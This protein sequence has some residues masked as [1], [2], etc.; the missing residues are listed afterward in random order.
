MIGD[1]KAPD[2][3]HAL[4]ARSSAPSSWSVAFALGIVYLVWGSTYAGIRVALGG[5]PPLLLA[6]IR[7]LTA[8]GLL[9]LY[10]LAR[11]RPLPSP[12]LLH[13]DHLMHDRP[14]H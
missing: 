8:G 6:G 12:G 13:Q 4:P 10:S 7:F 11:G 1:P 3:A 5:F 9:L 2:A 14:I